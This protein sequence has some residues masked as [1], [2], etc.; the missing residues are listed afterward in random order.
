MGGQV[1]AA[2]GRSGGRKFR[3]AVDVTMSLVLLLL[4]SY[5]MVG[6]ELHEVFGTALLVLLVVH[7]VLNRRWYTGLARGRWSASRV[8]GTVL[9]FAMLVSVGLTI[10]SGIAMSE[11]VF[12]WLDLPFSLSVARRLHMIFSSLSF[13]LM[14][15]HLGFHWRQMAVKILKG[16]KSW[17]IW[18]LRILAMIFAVY[19]IYV[20]YDRQIFDY[21]L[22]RVFF[23]QIRRESLLRFLFDYTAVAGAMVWIGYYANRLLIAA[24]RL[25]KSRK[26]RFDSGGRE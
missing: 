17:L 24:G 1:T 26:T 15:L 25:K 8:V 19:G 14:G 4:M 21:I 22:Q 5:M 16:K 7:H 10:F 2:S 20:I 11:F 12:S 6:R 23:Y 13:L 9:N 3:I 18:G